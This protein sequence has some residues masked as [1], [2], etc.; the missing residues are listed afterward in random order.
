MKLVFDFY[1]EVIDVSMSMLTMV[2]ISRAFIYLLLFFF[3]IIL[4]NPFWEVWKQKTPIVFLFL[5]M[6]LFSLIL[7]RHLGKHEMEA[8]VRSCVPC[9]HGGR[10]VCGGSESR[11][12]RLLS[13]ASHFSVTWNVDGGLICSGVSPFPALGVV[14]PHISGVCGCL[15]P[16]SPCPWPSPQA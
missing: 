16:G 6:S 15:V 13:L 1:I 7:R 9:P 10:Q 5:K 4:N 3:K 2:L 8:R 12:C 11:S 14:R